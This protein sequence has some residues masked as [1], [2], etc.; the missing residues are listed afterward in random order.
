MTTKTCVKCKS[1]KPLNEYGR[2]R[3]RPDGI[4]ERC[5]K[6]RNKYNKNAEEAKIWFN[7]HIE[8]H[9]LAMAKQRSRKHGVPC[10]L[11]LADIKIPESCPLLGITLF[12]GSRMSNNNAASL[13]RIDPTKGYTKDNVWII[14][15][16]ANLIKNNASLDELLAIAQNL[17]LFLDSRNSEK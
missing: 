7:T 1:E 14:S 17:R 12:R 5:K 2:D 8:N 6:C 16:R 13:D 3:S 10:D 4:S 11:T 15:K 9:M